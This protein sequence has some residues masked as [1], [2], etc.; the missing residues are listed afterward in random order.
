VNWLDYLIVLLLIWGLIR[1]AMKGFAVAFT[2]FIALY[3]ALFIGF[4]LMHKAGTYWAETFD[5]Q[6]PWIPFLGFL[7]VFLMIFLGIL[8][9]GKLLDKLFK[10]AAL[11]MLNRMAGALF[12]GI[13]MAFAMGLLIWLLDQ[14]QLFGPEDKYGSRLY[15]PMTLFANGIITAGTKLLPMLGDLMG[16]ID[17]L[18]D[19]LT[20]PETD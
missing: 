8:L 13:K 9:A 14:V 5:L 4:R 19:G 12:G 10:A 16:E 18:F 7:T 17:T 15:Q 3:I 11:G 2:S 20:L 6:T 1:G